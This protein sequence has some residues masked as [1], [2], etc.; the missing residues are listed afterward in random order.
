MVRSRPPR[1]FVKKGGAPGDGRAESGVVGR[2]AVDASDR[3][4][5]GAEI[6][7]RFAALEGRQAFHLQ[8]DEK[9]SS[10]VELSWVKS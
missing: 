3:R 8:R 5:Q 1:V 2:A 7:A 10:W 6:P 9:V 4:S